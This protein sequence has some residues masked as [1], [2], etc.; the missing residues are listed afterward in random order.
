MQRA[1]GTFFVTAEDAQ[2][3]VENWRIPPRK[4]HVAPYGTPLAAVPTRTGN[5]R[6]ALAQ[7]LGLNPDVP[8]FYFLGA[9]DYGPNVEALQCIITEV[10]PRLHRANKSFEILLAGKGLSPELEAAA[11]KAG[12]CITGFLPRLDDFLLAVDVM[13]N[14]VLRGGGIK[15][16]AVEALAWGNRVVSCASGAA[17][18]VQQICGSALRISADHNWD[19]FTQDAILLANNSAPVPSAFYDFYNLDA[20]ARTMLETMY[21]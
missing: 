21:L 13:L 15:T 18:L 20:V 2:W 9:L 6:K 7:S 11:K 1:A 8:W 3:A 12:I 4:C 5:E 10:L 14:P 17:G 19:Q 16:K